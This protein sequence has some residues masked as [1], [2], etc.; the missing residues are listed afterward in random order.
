MFRS[1]NNSKA[2]L[3]AEA[4]AA[5]ASP[6]PIPVPS[7]PPAPDLW[8]E[9]TA[10]HVTYFVRHPWEWVMKSIAITGMT[11]VD[12]PQD[13]PSEKQAKGATI[14]EGMNPV[15]PATR[16]RR[17]AA[18]RLRGPSTLKIE[19]VNPTTG[20][21]EYA[22]HGTSAAFEGMEDKDELVRT[23]QRCRCDNLNLS[24]PA[25]LISWDVTGDECINVIGKDLPLLP[26]N[27][28]KKKFAVLKEPMGSQGKGIYFVS[29]AEEIHKIIDEHRLRALKEPD[30]LDNLIAAKGRIPSWGKCYLAEFG[31][32]KNGDESHDAYFLWVFSSPSR[33]FS[34]AL[35]KRTT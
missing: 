25:V 23:L 30:M 18:R 28:E 24:P 5:P 17:N 12:G 3:L 31:M 33:S 6:P 16:R 27:K 20:L 10:P 8:S 34:S 21:L 4:A 11:Q 13:L 29:S 26:G 2:N 32:F 19:I 7:P 35:D 1:R 14:A 9:S 15:T 22:V